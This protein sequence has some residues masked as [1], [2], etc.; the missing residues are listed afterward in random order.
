MQEMPSRGKHIT[1]YVFTWI[2]CWICAL[3]SLGAFIT[4][5]KRITAG[6]VE[7]AN[8]SAKKVRTL[9]WVSLILAI[10]AIVLCIVLA[11]AGIL[12]FSASG[13]TYR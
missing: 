7:G 5:N 8:V 9:F 6:D 13:Y 2:F 1:M 11:A 3:I 12:T 4:M 10:V